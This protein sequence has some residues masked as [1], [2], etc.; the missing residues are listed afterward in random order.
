M[1]KK[2]H[3]NFFIENIKLRTILMK[4]IIL[5][6]LKEANSVGTTKNW[7]RQISAKTAIILL[8]SIF[9]I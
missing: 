9:D 1:Y 5:L 7:K 6:L 3:Y 4:K 8:P 2:I